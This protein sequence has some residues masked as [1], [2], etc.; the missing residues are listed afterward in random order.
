MHSEEHSHT[1]ATCV[2]CGSDQFIR[3]PAILMPFIAQRI[4]GWEPALIDESWELRTIP[5]GIAYPLCNS[6]LCEQCGL[7]F[8]DIRF[9]DNELARLYRNYRDEVY[10]QLREHYEPGYR[11]R[12]KEILHGINY[13]QDIEAFL[14]QHL[15]TT[16]SILDWGGD[17]GVNTPFKGN[18]SN[19]I[20]IYDISGV[21]ALGR[22]PKV[23]KQSAAQ[24]SYDL[25]VCSNVLE[26]VPYPHRL[27]G[28]IKAIMR[29]KTILYLEVPFENLL[30]KYEGGVNL[31]TKKRHWHEHI[32]FFSRNSLEVLVSEAGLSLLSFQIQDIESEG[33]TCSQFMLACGLNAS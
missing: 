30:K 33:K 15:P 21:E 8:L 10:I 18:P 12:N 20:H 19:A 25:I 29:P 9:S 16:L 11:K 32:N 28:E 2:C 27:L 14:R 13:M 23:S 4:Y 7:L 31:V 6:L 1:A 26:H 3:S 22:F 5:Q 24:N 17:T